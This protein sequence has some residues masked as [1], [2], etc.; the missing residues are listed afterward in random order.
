MMPYLATILITLLLSVPALS[1]ELF[2]YRGAAKDGGTLEYVFD[3]G[4]QNSPN[5]VTKEKAA[6]IAADF[7]TTF[8]HVQ[9][10][11][12]ESQEFRTTPAAFWL[13]CF[14]DTIKGP[15]RQMFFVVLL[16]DGTVVVPRVEK[17]L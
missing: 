5:A 15:M 9:V 12:L 3:A 10:G 14:S 8:Y 1:V 7:M 2:R 13:I 17:R 16:P 6:E 4:E 11:A